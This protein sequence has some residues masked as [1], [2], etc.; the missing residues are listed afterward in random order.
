M[1]LSLN[2]STHFLLSNDPKRLHGYLRQKKV[3]RP[4]IGPLLAD[5]V[6]IED[7]AGIANHLANQFTSVLTHDGGTPPYP[8]Q[9]SNS[10][11]V[12]RDF[13]VDDVLAALNKLKLSPSSGPDGLPSIVFR[14]CAMVLSYPLLIIFRKSL[15]S[16]S[17]PSPWKDS[18]VM[19]L[20]KGGIHSSPTNYR[21]ITK[22]SV[23]SKTL[24]RLIVSQLFEY[25][26]ENDLISIC[27]FGFRSGLSVSDQL[28]LAYEYVSVN[29]DHGNVVDMLYFDYAKAFDMVD[30]RIL[31]TKLSSIGIGNPLLG[32]IQ[33]FL[34]G[35]KMTV[36]VHGSSSRVVEVK[37]GVPQ[38][39]VMG[40]VLF[41]IFINH[42]VDGLSSKYAFFAGDLKI[43][44]AIPVVKAV[45]P[46]CS[47]LLQNDINL[48]ACRS[49][50]WGLSFSVNKCARIRFCRSTQIPLSDYFI[51]DTPI[52]NKTSFRDLGILVDSTM[53]F[54]LHINEVFRKAS[55]V[56]N[57]II[58]GTICRS[59]DFMI[60]VFIS[61]I[62]PIIDFGSVVWNTGYVGDLHL[63]ESVQRKWTKKIEGLSN[64]SYDERLSR[65]NLF[66][67]K[68]R[69]LR[70]DIMVWKIL[71]GS[72]PHLSELFHFLPYNRTR[73]H[74]LRLF[75]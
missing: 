3:D 67:I 49:K 72:S 21:P 45:N 9:I 17:V 55:G 28:L 42:V 75:F 12:L 8:H 7:Y 57:C 47:P 58:R 54:H 31:L 27:Q 50:S 44:L 33:D 36:V 38:G 64:Y 30:H 74:S 24:E 60:R 14:R 52:P 71:S 25:L 46:G 69:L 40:P 5:G 66:S 70:A 20:F 16:R 51:N 11:F 41:L 15:S 48:L 35:R 23:C 37:S 53:K 59:P 26:N 29:M 19:P 43:F 56:A 39:S 10:R 34:L 22:T 63:L 2:M 4:K 32:W 1:E 6:Y 62:R 65:L 73:E 13:T 68:G 18:D 61:H